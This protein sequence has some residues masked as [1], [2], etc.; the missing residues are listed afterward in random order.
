MKATL[1]LQKVT[2]CFDE[3]PIF[4]PIDCE[5]TAKQ[6]LHVQGRNGSG[7]TT[8]LEGVANLQPSQGSIT[9]NARPI[10]MDMVQYIGHDPGFYGHLTIEDNLHLRAQWQGRTH[11]S[12]PCAYEKWHLT[13]AQHQPCDT[14]SY[15]QKKKAAFMSLSHDILASRRALQ[16][17]RCTSNRH[18]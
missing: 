4:E 11:I 17:P 5:L 15:G 14:L 6:W 10:T 3:C 16:W 18:A 9:L 8:L 12:N 13:S 1:V 7:K 2:R